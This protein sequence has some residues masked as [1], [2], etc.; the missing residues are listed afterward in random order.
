MGKTCDHV[1]YNCYC[2]INQ[3]VELRYI[4]ARDEKH[5]ILRA[6]HIDPTGG[7]FGI[8]KTIC[9]VSERF[10][11]NGIVKDVQELVRQD[12]DACVCMITECEHA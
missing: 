1:N 11:W 6:C 4:R 8:K 2:I 9:K 10:M 3:V 5:R 7:H 12:I